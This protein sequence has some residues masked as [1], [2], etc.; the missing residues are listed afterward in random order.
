MIDHWTI[1]LILQKIRLKL[2]VLIIYWY[3]L[4]RYK[5]SVELGHFFPSNKWRHYCLWKTTG[6]RQY[7]LWILNLFLY[8]NVCMNIHF[9]VHTNFQMKFTCSSKCLSNW[10]CKLGVATIVQRRIVHGTSCPRRLLSKGQFS[11]QTLVQGD[12]CPR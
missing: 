9:N 8:I 2:I 3:Y 7:T 6:D 10:S 12:F 1:I 5:D 11:K 4:K